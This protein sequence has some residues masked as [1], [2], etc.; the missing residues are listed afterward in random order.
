V[1]RLLCIADVVGGVFL[2]MP[3]VLASL[4]PEADDLE[5]SILDIGDI[6]VD[7]STT[8]DV[9]ALE[10]DVLE[11]STGLQLSFEQLS[12]FA[13]DTTQVIDGLF[14]GCIEAAPRPRRHDA[15]TAILSEA[16]MVVAAFDS[17]VWLVSASEPVLARIMR[18]F[19]AVSEVDPA[20]TPLRAWG[21]TP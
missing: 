21:A 9:I 5:W 12:R 1:T 7:D 6:V 17:T 18:D 16:A 10:R 15:D 14:V 13:D 20:S 11:S 2:R 3:D 8:L 4:A 19:N